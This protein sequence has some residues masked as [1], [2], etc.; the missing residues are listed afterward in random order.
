M[1]P[2]PLGVGPASLTGPAPCWSLSHW[3]LDTVLPH[4]SA[5]L[6]WKCACD[7]K[8]VSE[9]RCGD[10][11]SSVTA[12][13]NSTIS[14]WYMLTRALFNSILAKRYLS[15]SHKNAEIEIPYYSYHLLGM[16]EGSVGESL[17][18]LLCCFTTELKHVTNTT[19][20]T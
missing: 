13:S 19:K 2:S 8:E 9:G 6:T 3:L 1:A 7:E 5:P 18:F 12:L 20:S 14:A 10:H 4:V 15:F 11:S 17:S 16:G